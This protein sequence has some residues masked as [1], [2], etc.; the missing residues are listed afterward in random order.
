MSGPSL[1]DVERQR[2][3]VDELNAQA[4]DERYNNTQLTLQFARDALEK[5]QKIHYTE[6]EAWAWRNLGIGHAIKGELE[7]AE[8]CLKK[9]IALFE[10]LEHPRGLGLSYSNLG[11]VYQQMGRLDKAVEYL[12]RSLRYLQ[13]IPELAF[14]YAQALANLGSLFGELEQYELAREYHEKALKIHESVG[15]KRG[16][17]FSL[18]SL[19]G[20][21]EETQQKEAAE[22]C[23]AQALD[24]ATELGEEDLVIRALL[25][26]AQLFHRT[27]RS[28][29]ALE[30]LQ[31]AEVL[32]QALDSPFLLYQLYVLMA[33]T[34]LA[35]HLLDK[36][37]EALEK[38]YVYREK[39]PVG[40]LDYFVPDIQAR[41]A[42]K[43][44]R[45]E[46]AYRYYKQYVEQRF[47][48]QRAVTRN[49]VGTLEKIL[50][51]DLLGAGQEASPD[52]LVAR[53]IQ[54]VM[55]HGEAELK[56][57]FPESVL[58]SVPKGVVSGDFLWAG[59][60]K[61]GAQILVIADASGAGVSAAM[62]STVAH[63]LLY[64]IISLRS[65]SD[66]GRILSQLHK[67]LLDILYPSAKK[68]APELEA[69][70]AEG[71]QVGI[72]AFFPSL[73]EVHFA[74]AHIPLWIY[75]P[76]L[77]WEQLAPDKRLI[78]QKAETEDR[79][80]RLYTSTIVPV[81]RGWTLLF[82]TDGW[83][84][85]VRASDGKRYG[86]SSVRDFLAAHPPTDL[87]EW[88]D[89]VRQEWDRWREGA[90]PTDD[91]LLVAT[92]T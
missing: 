60:G 80:P 35:L 49:V 86:R 91:I 8:S 70:Q 88:L 3:L 6:G 34:C 90:A 56:Q 77:G 53:R 23:L 13:L 79:T 85:Q 16:M 75:N 30:R 92:R 61:E 66:P 25:S 82:L 5:A 44:G 19:G 59:K 9:A 7:Q 12:V 39:A 4:Y 58:W 46:E 64:E 67:S 37:Q 55:L 62:L 15:A 57:I 72:L 51:E 33:D 52:L 17:F 1:P 84:R 81:E 22:N 27:G 2:K 43:A 29:E 20:F 76:A 83:E 47:A 40:S 36:A 28:K 65:V 74:G 38:V 24:I 54:E 89:T 41:L 18:V 50:R 42:E 31:R 14:F 69:I 63:V 21:Y 48:L 78:G 73:G 10:Q 71:F 11:T 87:K 26:Q 68:T 32:A 45:F